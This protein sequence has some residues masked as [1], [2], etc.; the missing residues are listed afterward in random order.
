VLAAGADGLRVQ[1]GT[2]VLRIT[3]LQA[4]GGKP[5]AV[6]TFLHGRP[7]APGTRFGT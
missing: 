3:R 7:I 1:C 4:E 2:G 6:E 5:L